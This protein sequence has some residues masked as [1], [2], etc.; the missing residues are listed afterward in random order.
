M[1]TTLPR[2]RGGLTSLTIHRVALGKEEGLF[3]QKYQAV[4]AEPDEH[5]AGRGKVLKEELWP[6]EGRKQWMTIA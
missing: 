6:E 2:A 4:I 3:R 5:F 1:L